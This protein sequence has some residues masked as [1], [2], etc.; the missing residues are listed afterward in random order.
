[1]GQAAPPGPTSVVTGQISYGW[2]GESWRLFSVQMGPWIVGVLT[3]AAPAFVFGIALYAV[4]LSTMFSNGFPGN[5]PAPPVGAN[6]LPTGP[7]NPAGNASPFDAQ[8]KGILPLEFGFIFLYAFW[9]AFMYGGLFRMAVQQVRGVPI[10][11]KDIFRGGLLFGRMLGVIFLLGLGG[12]ALEALCLAPT[13]IVAWR[14]GSG[15]ATG[16]T[17]A[18]G[19]VLLVVLGFLAYGLLLPAFALIADGVG[20]IPALKGSARAIKP[21]MWAAAGFV[22]VFGLLFY[23]S[24]L[25]CG[26]GLLATTPM[27]F[28][29]CALA[30]RDMVGMPNMAPPPQ[31]FYAPAGAGVWPPAP[32]TWPP[33][34]NGGPPPQWGATPGNNPGQTPQQY[35]GFPPQAYPSQT[36]PQ[37]QYPQ[38][39]PQQYSPQSPQQYPPVPPVQYP[40]AEP[41]P[42]EETPVNPWQSRPSPPPPSGE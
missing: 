12:Y 26:I 5:T 17:A 22:F 25:V 41:G 27:I 28:L 6:G 32:G 42:S 7:L 10:E 23:A 34:P 39:P 9:S 31:P 29:V 18:G 30:Y 21:R 13:G 19:I 37:Q 16:L 8:M 33:P 11:M 4:M 38:V 3:L 20:I 15:L 40:A 1:M 14:H 2:I 24:Y 36:P 35:P